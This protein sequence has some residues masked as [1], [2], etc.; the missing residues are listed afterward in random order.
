MSAEKMKLLEKVRN[1]TSEC[2]NMEHLY[3]NTEKKFL[4]VCI[5]IH[6]LIKIY[7]LISDNDIYIANIVHYVL[8]KH[9]KPYFNLTGAMKL[10]KLLELKQKYMIE[11]KKLREKITGIKTGNNLE[12]IDEEHTERETDAGNNDKQIGQ[13]GDNIK[14]VIYMSG[15]NY[16]K[17][18]L[19]DNLEGIQ[20]SSIINDVC[21][22]QFKI[23]D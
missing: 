19:P 6:I 5:Y 2:Q 22:P 15:P 8:A 4:K 20:R 12:Q 17:K 16:C 10:D 21:T 18:F 3:I 23:L 11:I 1:F 7:E 14:F 13:I 9:K